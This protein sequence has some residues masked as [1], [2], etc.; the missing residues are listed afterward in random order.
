MCVTNKLKLKVMIIIWRIFV[1]KMGPFG[2]LVALSDI[3]S[4]NGL[5]RVWM[6]DNFLTVYTGFSKVLNVGFQYN[7][8]F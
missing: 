5:G 7:K 1:Q 2:C 3:Q 8:T 4:L 6:S